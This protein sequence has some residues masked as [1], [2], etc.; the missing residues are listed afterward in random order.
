VDFGVCVDGLNAGTAPSRDGLTF[1][2]SA[3][4]WGCEPAG[5]CHLK[6]YVYLA[7][8]ARIASSEWTSLIWDPMSTGLVEG[9]ID[10]G[11]LTYSMTLAP[12]LRDSSI[13]FAPAFSSQVRLGDL[14]ER[15]VSEDVSA[16]CRQTGTARE[17]MQ[18]E[19]FSAPGDDRAE[20]RLVRAQGRL[21]IVSVVIRAERGPRG[22]LRPTSTASVSK[23]MGNGA[24]CSVQP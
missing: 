13:E 11:C 6:R 2:I 17:P 23:R 16:R 19:W 8:A 3:E 18:V 14:L 12:D 5:D 21:E 9:E 15:P 4:G 22:T 20:L 10:D 7:G 1:T 24:S